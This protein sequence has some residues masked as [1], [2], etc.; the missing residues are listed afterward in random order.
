MRRLEA[1]PLLDAL[2]AVSGTLN[3]AMYG[4]SESVNRLE[5]GEVVIAGDATEPRRSIYVTILRLNPETL[6]EAFDQPPPVLT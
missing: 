1:E 5:S 6:L 3:A 2:H 4:P